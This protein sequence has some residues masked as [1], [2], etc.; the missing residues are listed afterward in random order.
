MIYKSTHTQNYTVLPNEIFNTINNGLSIGILAYLLSRPY[1]W[2]TY[3]QQLYKHF[4]EGRTRIDQAFTILEDLGYIVGVQKIDSSGKFSGFEWVVYDEPVTTVNRLTENRQSEIVQ[5]ISKEDNKERNNK[6]ES[7]FLFWNGYPTKVGKAKVQAKWSKLSIKEKETIL[8]S[9]PKYV[10]YKPFEGYTHPNPETFLNQRRWEDEAYQTSPNINRPP[11][12]PLAVN[13][14]LKGSKDTLDNLL[15]KGW[16]LEELK[17][18]V[19]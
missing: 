12:N 11:L 10:A 5:L 3:K 15:S 17:A 8:A 1:N 2:V 14:A 13:M 18:F 4:A 16:T 6:D 9:L 7:F 19:A